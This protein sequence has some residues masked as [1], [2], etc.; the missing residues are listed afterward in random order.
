M[1]EEIPSS[2]TSGNEKSDLRLRFRWCFFTGFL[3][4]FVAILLFKQHFF[5]TGNVLVQCKLWQYYYLEGYRF[6]T[7]SGQLGPTYGSGTQAAIV[8]ANHVF[9]SLVAGLFTL[10]LSAALIKFRTQRKKLDQ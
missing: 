5:F 2:P 9:I 8:F 3:L 10:G 1:T 4:A 7:S 6:F